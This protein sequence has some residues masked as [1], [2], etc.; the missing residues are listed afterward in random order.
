MKLTQGING[1]GWRKKVWNHIAV[2]VAVAVGGCEAARRMEELRGQ[3]Y[4]DQIYQE[5]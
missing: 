2:A 4:H 1:K 3:L 5:R